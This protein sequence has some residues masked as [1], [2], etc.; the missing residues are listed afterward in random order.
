MKNS[1]VCFA[2][3]AVLIAL[4][5]SCVSVQDREMNVNERASTQIAGTITVELSE[6]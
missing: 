1:V 6:I 3:V 2:A 5:G 4:L